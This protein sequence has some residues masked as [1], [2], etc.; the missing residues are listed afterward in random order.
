VPRLAVSGSLVL[1]LVSAGVLIYFIHHLARS[2]QIDAI[3]GQV[4]REARWV[5]DDLDP[6]GSGYLEPEQRC[7]DPPA[8]AALLPAGR[9]GY[10][11]AVQPEPLIRAAARQDLVVWLARRVGDHVVAGTPLAFA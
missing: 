10:F 6:N 2:I 7:P 8:W 1:G 11:Q 4:E 5:I 9:S 3:M